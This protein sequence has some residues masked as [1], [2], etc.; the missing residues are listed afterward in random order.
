LLRPL[1]GRAWLAD[2]LD[3]AAARLKLEQPTW[4]E[5][6]AE[7]E[8]QWSLATRVRDMVLGNVDRSSLMVASVSMVTEQLEGRIDAATANGV[9]WGSCSTF[10]AMVSLFLELDTDLEVLGSRRNAGLTED[11][12]NAL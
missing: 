10:V 12:V 4:R 11:E 3:E 5:A 1:P 6:E 9:R 8:D 2:R 7:L